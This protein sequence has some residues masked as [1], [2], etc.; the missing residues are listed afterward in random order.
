[1]CTYYLDVAFVHFNEIAM[2]LKLGDNFP[3]NFPANFQ[4]MDLN[5]SANF[6][7]HG[8]WLCQQKFAFTS[9][10]GC[11]M[12]LPIAFPQTCRA[13]SG[14]AKNRTLKWTASDAVLGLFLKTIYG[15]FGLLLAASSYEKAKYVLCLIFASK[16]GVCLLDA[17]SKTDSSL[18][19]KLT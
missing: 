2:F 8:S 13:T 19:G 17:H 3:A 7:N 15:H 11:R 16:F 18:D 9:L 1:M 12:G 4:N 10:L 6:E 14:H 5:F